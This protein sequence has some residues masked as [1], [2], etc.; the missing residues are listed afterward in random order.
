LTN[1]PAGGYNGNV[2]SNGAERLDSF[3]ALFLRK[4]PFLEKA[5]DKSRVIA[6]GFP[7][8]GSIH[9]IMGRG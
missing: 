2:T 3:P 9:Q 7:G 1:P 4:T 5:R 6:G 8:A